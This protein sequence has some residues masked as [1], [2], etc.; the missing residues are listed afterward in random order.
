M[1]F[2][3]TIFV[4]HRRQNQWHSH[5][6]TAAQN[7]FQ[8]TG[9]GCFRFQKRRGSRTPIIHARYAV[10]RGIT[11]GRNK[12]NYGNYGEKDMHT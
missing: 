11:D 12:F 7:N 1:L 4:Q 3:L 10:W 5:D 9:R 6:N 8:L 2:R